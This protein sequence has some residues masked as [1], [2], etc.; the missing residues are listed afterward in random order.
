[1]K[2]FIIFLVII[3]IFG[4]IFY[5]TVYKPFEI[6]KDVLKDPKARQAATHFISKGAL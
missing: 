2:L 4:A 3:A 5:I 1:M 6:A